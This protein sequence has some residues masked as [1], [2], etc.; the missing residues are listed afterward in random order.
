MRTRR[1]NPFLALLF[2]ILIVLAIPLAVPWAFHMGERWTP[3]LTWSG[4]GTLL[5]KNGPHP[6]FVSFYPSP[7]FSRLRLDGLQPT[8]GLQGSGCI[9]LAP[10]SFQSLKLSGTIYGAWASTEGSLMEF[11]LLERTIVDVGQARAGYFDL[12]GRWAGPDLVMDDR[13]RSSRAFRSG[14]RAER[15]SVT[16]HWNSAWTCRTVCADPAAYR[17]HP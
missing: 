9:C 1:R 6:L 2:A 8:G 7:H 5:T 13:G 14:L 16:L 17:A 3:L 11:R 12:Y 15:A 10:G 4:S